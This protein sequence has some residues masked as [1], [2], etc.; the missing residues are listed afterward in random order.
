[1]GSLDVVVCL[2]SCPGDFTSPLVHDPPFCAFCTGVGGGRG[3]GACFFPGIIIDDVNPG[4]LG[5]AVCGLEG[6]DI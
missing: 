2:L 1:M 4:G 6:S 5:G 3:G